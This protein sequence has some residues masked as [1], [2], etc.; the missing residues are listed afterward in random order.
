MPQLQKVHKI[1]ATVLQ[2]KEIDEGIECGATVQPVELK[3]SDAL[4]WFLG[5]WS[6]SIKS[7][8]ACSTCSV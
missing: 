1:E 2:A 6:Q 7:N 3:G 4:L 8:T 5:Y